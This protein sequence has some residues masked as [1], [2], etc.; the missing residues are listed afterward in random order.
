[1]R[2]LRAK[3]QALALK[4]REAEKKKDNAS[5]EFKASIQ[6]LELQKNKLRNHEREIEHLEFEKEK[7]KIH[8]DTYE[9]EWHS[10]GRTTEDLQFILR[11]IEDKA[12]FP[13]PQLESKIQKL[14]TE[15]ASIGD[16]DAK[17][18]DEAEEAEKRFEFL[19][20]EWTDIEHTAKNLEE[21]ILDLD[22]RIHEDFKKAFSTINEEFAKHFVLM[23][24]G[25]HAKMKLTSQKEKVE[26]DTEAKVETAEDFGIDIELSLPK[27][28]ISNLEMLSGG[29]K[30]LVS[31]AALFALI[32]VSPPPF[33]VLDE[34]DAPLDEANAKR[35]ADL[36]KACSE[37]TQ[38]V[39]ITH[40][41]V[42]MEAADILYGVTMGDDG[43]SKILSLDL[44]S[45]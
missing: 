29:E 23:F 27:K 33:L 2:I 16:I 42:T 43:V 39:V 25:G 14:R 38:C 19:T 44:A 37:K 36:I 20:K 6:S 41:R 35:F 11:N 10:Y 45:I 13:D 22:K 7:V 9:R 17:T 1:M 24:G 31:L 18:I 40:N 12:T 3:L 32:S 21:L 30:S 5:D 8:I 26:G 15:L 28:K 4:E 34:I